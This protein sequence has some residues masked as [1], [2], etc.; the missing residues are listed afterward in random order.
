MRYTFFLLFMIFQVFTGFAQVSLSE[1][2]AEHKSTFT[3]QNQQFSGDGWGILSEQVKSHQ[4]VLIGEDHFYNEVPLFVAQVAK[5]EKFNNFFCEIDP[6][7][8]DIISDKIRSLSGEQLN[9]Y[10][11]N[12]SNTFS[13]YALKPE[14]D[15]LKQLT[16]D[17]T[18]II[19]T[20]QIVLVADRLLASELISITSNSTAK[21]IYAD[22]IQKS[23]EHFEL[24]MQQKGSP[25]FFT[26][27]F[28]AN[29]NKLESLQL[30][31]LEKS[32]I[33]DLK[34]SRKIYTTQDHYLRIQLMKN[35]VLQYY[36]KFIN[37]KNLFKYGGIHMN[38]GESQL[39]GYDIGNLVSNL[40]DG[41]FKSSLHIMVLGKSGMQGVPFKGMQPQTVNP[42]SKDLKPYEEFFDQVTSEEW[43]LFDLKKIKQGVKK[44]GIAI[45][46]SS[47]DNLLSGFDYL[48]VIPEVTAAGF[49]D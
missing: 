1:L 13:F 8:A 42:D 33:S 30:S 22:I 47:L 21:G 46:D 39:G 28:T 49:M 38:K 16:L 12:I 27:E 25:Y 35:N 19:G 23:A 14:F 5:V 9:K 36:D 6:Y 43:I 37:G 29:L 45:D 34:L 20:D 32:I 24:F 41:N 48:V 17:G 2:I 3:Y 10:L 18:E 31:D 4:S 7:S 11:K 44:N 15:L 26:E 40:A